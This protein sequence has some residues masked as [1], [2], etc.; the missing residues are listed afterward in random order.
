LW[1]QYNRAEEALWWYGGWDLVKLCKEYHGAA[2]PKI[3]PDKKRG[4]FIHSV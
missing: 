4:V 2:F 3:S 1:A